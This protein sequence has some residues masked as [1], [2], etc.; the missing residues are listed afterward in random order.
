MFR[1]F[2]V[3]GVLGVSSVWV[4]KVRDILEGQQ[5]DQGGSPKMAKI[6]HGVR[7]D[8]FKRAVQKRPEFSVGFGQKSASNS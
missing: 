1:C 4:F 7:P 3:L 5:G 8:I 6:Q 2:G